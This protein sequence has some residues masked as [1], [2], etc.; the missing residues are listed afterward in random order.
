MLRPSPHSTS[1]LAHC[2][3]LVLAALAA[4]SCAQTGDALVADAPLPVRIQ[5][6]EKVPFQPLLHLLGTVG[7]ATTAEIPA[8]SGGT[9]RYAP[10]FAGGLAGGMPVAAGELLATIVSPAPESRVREAEIAAR[11]AQ[12]ELD[13]ARRGVDEGILAR[14][15]LERAETEDELARERVKSSVREVT[16]TQ[17]RSPIAGRLLVPSATPDGSQVAPQLRLATVVAIGRLRVETQVPASDLA[18]LIPGLTARF[19]APSTGTE[20]GRGRLREIAPVADV[21]GTARAVIEVIDDRGMPVP[22][23]GVEVEIE[24]P[25]RPAA[26]LLPEEA[27]VSTDGGLAAYRIEPRNDQLK[28]RLVPVRTGERSGGKIEVLEGLAEGDRVAVEGVAL[29]HDGSVVVEEAV[30]GELVPAKA[31]ATGF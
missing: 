23:A 5:K 15:Q 31:G 22:G 16:V 17:V 28:A 1:P 2:I 27:L 24:L 25:S 11:G 30:P 21:S 20:V 19:L 13:R 3:T 10:R 12:R 9:L 14:A 8:P 18:R 29:L 6:L 26:L 7:P 4:C